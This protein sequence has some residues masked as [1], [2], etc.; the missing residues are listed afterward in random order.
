MRVSVYGGI[1]SNKLAG[2][3]HWVDLKALSSS[4]RYLGDGEGGDEV[5]TSELPGE[6][7]WTVG[8]RPWSCDDDLRS[9]P[10]VGY[11]FADTIYG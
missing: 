11:F 8:V 2:V 6:G 3:L 5:S 1:P 4:L 9:F 7:A 10:N